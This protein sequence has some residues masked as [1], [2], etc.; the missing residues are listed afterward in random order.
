ART[1]LNWSS[2]KNDPL[3][4]WLNKLMATKHPCKVVVSLANKLARII[5]AV[6]TTRKPFDVALA[7]S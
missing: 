4:Q 1:V 5:W 6:L 3:S 7:S 2:K